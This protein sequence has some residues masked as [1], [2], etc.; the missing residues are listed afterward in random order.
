MFVTVNASQWILSQMLEAIP[1]PAPTSIVQWAEDHVKLIGSARSESYR[2]NIT[3]WTVEPIECGNDGT[4]RCT[5]VK[6]IQAGGSSVGEIVLMF[7]L[8]HWLGGDVQYNWPSDTQADERWKKHTEKKLRACKPLMARTS[9]DRFAWS[10]GLIIFPHANFMVQGVWTDRS[11]TADS[12]RGQVNEE[13]HDEKGWT[14]GRLK[15]AHGRCTAFWNS[16]IF[17]I[18]N[19]G[20]KNSE[21]HKAFTG[22]TCQHWQVLCPGCGRFHVMRTRWEDSRPELGGLRYDMDGCRMENGDVNYERL[23]GTIFYQM[24]CGYKVHDDTRERRALSRSGRYSEPTNKGAP[25]TERSYHL[26]AISVDFVSWLELIQEKHLALRA[27]KFGDAIPWLKYLRERESQFVDPMED[28]PMIRSVQFSETKKNRAGLSN[29]IARF[30]AVDRQRGS[31]EGGIMPH[32]WM[33]LEDIALNC[34]CDGCLNREPKGEA[35]THI[36]VVWEGK[37]LVDEDVTGTLKEHEVKPLHVVVDSSYDAPFVYTFALRFGFNCLKISGKEPHTPFTKYF[38]HDD[39]SH[40]IFSAPKYLHQMIGQ[41]PSRENEAEEPEFW[42]ISLHGALER[43]FYLRNSPGVHYEIP[44]D[45]SQDFLSHMES[46]ELQNQKIARTNE[47]VQVWKQV[48]KRDDLLF[49]AAALAVTF[50]M[51]ELI[52]AA[53]IPMSEGVTIAATPSQEP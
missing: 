9:P 21:L 39:G 6:P 26:E 10:K 25:L 30:A 13:L 28:R 48:K 24:P 36:L 3:P 51:A 2:A 43:L 5:F 49:C 37:C 53:A 35:K 46:W 34:R 8:S 23:R 31:L 45:I 12:V 17:N 32:W 7:W 18:S 16:V 52:G 47:T 1:R 14:P 19:G 42:F 38:K 11:V 33:L 15:Q 29:R 4:R 20:R 27:L 40:R 22:G 41:P 44:K 50:E